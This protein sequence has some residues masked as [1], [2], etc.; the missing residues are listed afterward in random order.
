MLP[1]GGD[2]GS[3]G[4]G[5]DQVSNRATGMLA[6]TCVG[7]TEAAGGGWLVGWLTC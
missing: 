1:K 6:M 4:G 2:G 5:E 3:G 7:L